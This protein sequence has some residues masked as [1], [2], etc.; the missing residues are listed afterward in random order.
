M[1]T[2]LSSLATGGCVARQPHVPSNCCLG[3]CYALRIWIFAG[4][5]AL[6]EFDASKQWR[7]RGRGEMR[8]NVAPRYVLQGS[9]A[10]RVVGPQRG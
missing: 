9:A 8:L 10:R 7:E 5:G 1:G 4:E 3:P 6:F 2:G